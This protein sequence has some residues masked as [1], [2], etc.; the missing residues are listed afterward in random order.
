MLCRVGLTLWAH[1]KGVVHSGTPRVT[2]SD[3]SL[4]PGDCGIQQAI[5][6][7]AART[8]WQSQTTSGPRP[9]QRPP[10]GA[11]DPPESRATW[12][13]KNTHVAPLRRGSVFNDPFSLDKALLRGNLMPGH[14]VEPD[15][16]QAGGS[17]SLLSVIR[18]SSNTLPCAAT[19]AS[20]GCEPRTSW[21]RGRRSGA[22]GRMLRRKRVPLSSQERG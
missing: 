3:S 4:S 13:G 12:H 7:R 1:D 10:A 19:H 9:G 15:R 11:S 22:I 17:R 2:P 20:L 5:T 21:R 6:K 8:R 14:A 16:F 18:T